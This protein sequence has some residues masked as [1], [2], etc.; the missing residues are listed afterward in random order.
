MRLSDYDSGS[1]SGLDSGS[2]I[3]STVQPRDTK[4]KSSSI[5][6]ALL[7]AREASRIY[8]LKSFNVGS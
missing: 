5:I 1:G 6:I 4:L 2:G 8:V 3:A 7:N